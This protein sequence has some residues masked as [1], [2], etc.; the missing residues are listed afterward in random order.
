MSRI[1]RLPT[2]C[3]A[4]GHGLPRVRVIV[5][6]GGEWHYLRIG[7][8]DGGLRLTKV[9]TQCGG[10][11]FGKQCLLNCAHT[12]AAITSKADFETPRLDLLARLSADMVEA[13]A[14]TLGKGCHR[15]P[16]QPDTI[17]VHGA[18]SFGHHQ[19]CTLL[20]HAMWL[21]VCTNKPA[22][23][24]GPCHICAGQGALRGGRLGS[25]L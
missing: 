5:K 10:R 8:C 21:V 6:W 14:A 16:W 4:A 24:P 1:D 25:F 18:G 9:C 2:N 17:L 7:P 19:A 15:E 22:C 12:G 11:L 23:V 3:A 20:D 13:S